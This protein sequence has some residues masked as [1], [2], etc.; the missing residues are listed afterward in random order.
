MA[1]MEPVPG[2]RMASNWLTPNI[3]RFEMVNV[4][5]LY[6]AGDSRFSLACSGPRARKHPQSE[7]RRATLNSSAPFLRV[8]STPCQPAINRN[9]HGD[10]DIFVVSEGA[11]MPKCQSAKGPKR[12]SAKRPWLVSAREAFAGGSVRLT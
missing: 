8:P 3:P 10:V 5:V 6:S 4:P 9:G 7:E 2:G 12:P 11:R 1:R